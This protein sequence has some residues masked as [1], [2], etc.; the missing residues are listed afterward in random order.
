MCTSA[1]PYQSSFHQSLTHYSPVTIPV[2]CN[3]PNL[4]SQ[5]H[6]LCL[7]SLRCSTSIYYSAENQKMMYWWTGFIKDFTFC[8]P[9]NFLQHSFRRKRS[10]KTYFTLQSCQLLI[11]YGLLSKNKNASMWYWRNYTLPV[12]L[13]LPQMPCGLVSDPAQTSASKP[14]NILPDPWYSPAIK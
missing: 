13:I 14:A 9:H 6:N 3:T 5:Y 4:S 12:P 7:C 10:T 8:K 11:V 2:T 1:S